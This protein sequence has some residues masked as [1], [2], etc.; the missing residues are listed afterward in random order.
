MNFRP[1]F[2]LMVAASALA[3]SDSQN[4][5]TPR[6]RLTDEMRQRVAAETPGASQRI[7]APD[8]AGAAVMLAPVRVTGTYQPPL[9]RYEDTWPRNQP[10]TAKD[11][12]TLWRHDAYRFTTELKFQY[13]PAHRGFDLL[14]FSW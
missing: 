8:P 13:N 11:G 12:G 14:S 6:P 7:P 9:L 5:P 10:F 2:A 4:A 1:L 3:A